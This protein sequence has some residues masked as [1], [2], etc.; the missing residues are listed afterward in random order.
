MWPLWPLCHARGRAGGKGAGA[1]IG[2]KA[3]ECRC[4]VRRRP[5]GEAVWYPQV[6]TRESNSDPITLDLR[7]AL[8]VRRGV[9]CIDWRPDTALSRGA[10][11]VKR[12]DRGGSYRR[13][14]G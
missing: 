4:Q 10:A 7:R 6:C 9:G 11:Q 5:E 14:S 1:L 13:G 3:R 12:G 2:N 8:R